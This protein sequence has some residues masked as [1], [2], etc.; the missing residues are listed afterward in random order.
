VVRAERRIGEKVETESRYYILSKALPA[1]QFGHAVRSHWRIENCVHWVLDTAFRE[2]ESRVR[3]G[4]AAENLATL[5]HMALNLLKKH[6]SKKGSSIRT[7]RLRAGWDTNYLRR[8]LSDED[9]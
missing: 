1:A 8:L 6:P 3:A 5:R 7:R 2:D 4:Y 9:L